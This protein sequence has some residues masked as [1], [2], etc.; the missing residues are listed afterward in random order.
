MPREYDVYDLAN[1]VMARGWMA[2]AY[3]EILTR[4]SEQQKIAWPN[5]TALRA[6]RAELLNRFSD[7]IIT[8]ETLGM[9][10]EYVPVPL[11][12]TE[13][14]SFKLKALPQLFLFLAQFSL[15]HPR[16]TARALAR[17]AGNVLTVVGSQF[18][19]GKMRTLR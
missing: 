2:A 17:R 12:A 1:A 6:L 4:R 11:V 7:A 9:V 16:R 14:G 18:H 10:D 19:I 5:S 13:L 15:R 3:P 8:R